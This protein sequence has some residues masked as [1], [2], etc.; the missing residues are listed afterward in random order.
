MRVD[1]VP[2]QAVDLGLELGRVGGRAR[3]FALMQLGCEMPVVGL[4]GVE[5]A[6]QAVDLRAQVD[7]GSGVSDAT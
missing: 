7:L 5:L 3:A 1:Q 2:V 6:A 4:G